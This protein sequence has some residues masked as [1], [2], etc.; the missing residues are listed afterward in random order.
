M[1]KYLNIA[2][3]AL[4]ELQLNPVL[5]CE[6]SEESEK[7]AR[8]PEDWNEQPNPATATEPINQTHIDAIKAEHPVLVWCGVFNEWV[9]WV[10]DEEIK[11]RLQTKGCTLPIYT[12]GELT[13]IATMPPKELARIHSY[14]KAFG[15]TVANVN[16]DD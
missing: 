14:K 15:A 7:R 9:Y 16:R 2:R 4:S 12:L 6:K 11:H 10:R 8:G 3:E 13:S 5:S 1:G